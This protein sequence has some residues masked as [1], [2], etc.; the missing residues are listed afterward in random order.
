M[1]ELDRAYKLYQF[2]IQKTYSCF[3]LLQDLFLKLNL[4]SIK[5]NLKDTLS[6][7]HSNF[8]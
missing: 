7:E 3:V 4:D 8:V 6:L 5:I 1:S 2:N